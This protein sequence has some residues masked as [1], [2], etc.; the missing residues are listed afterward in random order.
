[1]ELLSDLYHMESRFYLFADSA[2]MDIR[3][4]QGFRRTYHWLENHFGRT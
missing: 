3:L 1:M 4:V 2:N